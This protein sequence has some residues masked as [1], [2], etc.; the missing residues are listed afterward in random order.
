MFKPE[1]FED[2]ETCDLMI[3]YY[4]RLHAGEARTEVL[5]QV[6]PGMMKS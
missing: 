5:R 3:T 2:A 4:R 6:Q 1:Y